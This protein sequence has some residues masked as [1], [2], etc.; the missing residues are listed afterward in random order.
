MAK[1]VVIAGATGFIGQ[2]LCRELHGDYEIVA[3]SRDATRGTDLLGQYAGVVEWDARTASSW[4]RHVDGAHAVVNL[5]GENLAAGRWTPAR[6]AG[7]V[8]SRTNSANAVVDAVAGARNKPAVIIQASGINY[9]GSRNDEVLDE[10]SEVGDGFLAD[11]CRRTEAIATRVEKSGV[12]P[13]LV[14]SGL[15]LGCDGGVLPK[16]MMPFRFYIGGHVGSG[17]QWVSWISLQDEV[18][19]IRF[20]MEHPQAQGAYNLAAPNPVTMKQF[21][22]VLGRVLHSPAWTFVPGFALR[23]ALGELA[24]EA[25]LA[26]VKALP[27]RLLEAG[28]KFHYPELQDALEAIIRGEEP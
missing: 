26:S 18:R 9:Y 5:A 8:Q 28:F 3:V 4:A 17:R 14:R 6:K 24:D 25:L 23:L 2:T 11:V 1:R 16:F 10:S 22:R 12:R 19:A 20:L 21:A 13:V 7:M 15:V 27:N